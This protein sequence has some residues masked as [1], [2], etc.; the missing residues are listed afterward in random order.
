MLTGILEKII[1][2]A[3]ID[4]IGQ[5]SEHGGTSAELAPSSSISRYFDGSSSDAMAVLI[6]S[7]HENQKTALD[8]LCSICNILT[9]CKTI[10][11][12]NLTAYGITVATQ[13]NYVAKENDMWIYSCI[14]NLNIYN[15]E[16]F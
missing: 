10:K 11:S 9:R 1:E 7:K 6:L 2:I 4:S 15:K 5:L 14:I 8:R 3:D 13:P 12:G 16:E